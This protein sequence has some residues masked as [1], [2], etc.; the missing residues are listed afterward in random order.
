MCDNIGQRRPLLPGSLSSFTVFKQCKLYGAMQMQDNFWDKIFSIES[1]KDK[2]LCTLW[3]GDILL[4]LC[5]LHVT[6][7][8]WRPGCSFKRMNF[9]FFKRMM[10][11]HGRVP[12]GNENVRI[13][14]S[15]INGWNMKKKTLSQVSFSIMAF[16]GEYRI[17]TN[18]ITVFTRKGYLKNIS[19]FVFFI[20][21]VLTRT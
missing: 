21:I 15:S 13:A 17:V 2:F 11:Q 14:I 16:V 1:V 8:L 6:A 18:M 3:A 20:I 9:F 10:S 12:I 19:Y 5:Y 4:K 7:P